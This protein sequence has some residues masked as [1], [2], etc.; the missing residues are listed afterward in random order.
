MPQ[1][2]VTI[3]S[4]RLPA[5]FFWC[6]LCACLAS[7]TVRRALLLV[8]S[9]SCRSLFLAQELLPCSTARCN[10]SKSLGMALRQDRTTRI[11]TNRGCM[12]SSEV[13]SLPIARVVSSMALTHDVN[14]R[15]IVGQATVCQLSPCQRRK[16]GEEGT[17][18]DVQLP[19]NVHLAPSI[20]RTGC[21]HADIRKGT[22][23]LYVG[24]EIVK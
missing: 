7:T 14:S 6:V 17:E 5:S 8:T 24:Y 2:R 18:S 16:H 21:A 23:E 10:D 22:V 11:G 1:A 12:K 20:D 13:V 19:H 4:S 15:T 9:S 3:T